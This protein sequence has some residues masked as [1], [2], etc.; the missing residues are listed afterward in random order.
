MT[1]VP[2]ADNTRDLR[3]SLGRFA[4][5]VTV[6]TAMSDDGPIGMTV[7][8]FSS[9][10]LDP[11]LIAWSLAKRSGR[12]LPFAGAHYFSV[13]VLGSTQAEVAMRFARDATAFDEAHW[14]EGELEMP[15]LKGALACFECSREFLYEGGDHTIIIGRVEY[16]TVGSGEPL[17][18]YG[19][20]FGDFR[21]VP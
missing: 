1:F 16:A 14:E 12:Y 2:A 19:G 4:T 15:V 5:G 18:F 6:L 13:N 11:P 20:A 8:S 10:S 3:T 7:N 9:V 17:L 21:R